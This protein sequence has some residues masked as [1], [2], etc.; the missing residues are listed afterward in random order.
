MNQP[1]RQLDARGLNCPLPILRAKRA[2]NRM[3][4][5]EILAIVATDP[6]AVADFKAFAA[7]TG[8]AL[9]LSTESDGE[10]HFQVRKAN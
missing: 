6:G 4:A 2:L 10:F 3:A 8:H 5:G 1:T 7:Q 9:L